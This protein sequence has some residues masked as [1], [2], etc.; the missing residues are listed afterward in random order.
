VTL[1]LRPLEEA[2]HIAWNA[3]VAGNPA[4]GFGQSWEWADFKEQEGHLVDRMGLFVGE[5]LVGGAMLHSY[6]AGDGRSVL[7]APDGPV[8]PWDDEQ[9]ARDALRLIVAA[10]ADLAARRKAISLRIEPHLEGARPAVLRRFVRAPLDVYPESTLLVDVDRRDA[11]LLAQMRPKGRY[12]VRLAA[13]RGVRVERLP[14]EAGLRRF[15]ALFEASALRNDFFSEPFGFFINL[16][17]SLPERMLRCYVSAHEDDDLAAALVIHF[18]ARATYLYGGSSDRKRSL[19]GPYAMHF[20]AMRDA[21]DS[22]LRV[23]DFYGFEPYGLVDHQY[24]GFSRFKRQFGG[25]PVRYL[26]AQDHVFYDALADAVAEGLM[27]LDALFAGAAGGR[28][29]HAG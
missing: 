18:G 12:N 3:L 2:D 27:E 13:R 20:E 15:H 24:A 23:Y 25:R 9:R 4:S 29:S 21:R 8:V 17:R 7:F 10:A 6:P 1:A 11:E 14:A 5:R 28:S 22:G 16:A 26:G 19:M